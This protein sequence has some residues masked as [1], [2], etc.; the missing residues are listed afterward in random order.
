[1]ERWYQFRHQ[2][3]EGVAAKIGAIAA[4]DGSDAEPVVTGLRRFY[5]Y[6]QI[7][8]VGEVMAQGPAS[9]F[10]CG[11]G[12]TCEVGAIQMR[13]GPGTEVTDEI[14]PSLSKQP[15]VLAAAREL[16]NTLS[17]RLHSYAAGT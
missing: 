14:T 2:G 17:D 3:G 4:V 10:T 12:E 7:D 1:M 5:Q 11:F 13:F 8:C 9:C 15:E 6:N 16:G